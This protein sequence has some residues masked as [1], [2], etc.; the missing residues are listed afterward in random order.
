MKYK[1]YN[2]NITNGGIDDILRNRGITEIDKW[3]NASWNDINSPY[4]FG[5][6]KVEKA[7]D[8]LRDIF[9]W[10]PRKWNDDK[11]SGQKVCV[12]VD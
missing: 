8:F 11:P 6:K 4:A 2:E 10:Q 5:R 7:V 1:L 12:V 3:K 9:N